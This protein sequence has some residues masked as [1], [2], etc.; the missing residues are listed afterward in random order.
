MKKIKTTSWKS[1]STSLLVLI[2]ISLIVQ[3]CGGS[4]DSASSAPASSDAP[5]PS[6]S[7]PTMENMKSA[8]VDAIQTISK[9]TVSEITNLAKNQK[10]IQ[11]PDS[12][13]KVQDALESAGKS[14]LFKGFASSLNGSTVSALSGYK[15]SLAKTIGSINIA[16]VE[17]VIK[18]GDDSMTRYLE[19]T[20]NSKLK[21]NLIPFVKDAI[22]DTQADEWFEKIKGALP[23]DTGGL[24]GKVSAATGV[25]IP[26]DFDVEGYLTDEIM[27]KFFDIMANQEKLFRQDPKGRSADLFKKVMAAAQ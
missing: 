16:D 11:I 15:D 9:N 13:E 21:Q 17:K 5:A 24:L 18:G 27:S 10:A 2:A 22:K 1:I 3:G 6:S 8:V 12:L 20:A 4:K 23:K 7:E 19:S 25:S 14:D 26:T